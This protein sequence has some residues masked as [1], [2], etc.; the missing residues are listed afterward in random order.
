MTGKHR[1]AMDLALVALLACAATVE[2]QPLPTEHVT[3]NAAKLAPAE[4]LRDFVRT[5]TARSGA[6]GKMARWKSGIC[7]VVT[8]LPEAHSKFVTARVRQVARQVGAPVGAA[9]CKANIDI[10][11]TL[12]PQ[13]LM[14]DVRQKHHVYL[15]Y[16]EV[17][18]EARL[19][20][21]THPVQAWYTT[22]TVDL[23]GD[24]TVDDKLRNNGGYSIAGP[25]GTLNVTEPAPAV[26]VTG[27]R[28]MDGLSSELY[29][30]II[31]V[32]LARVHG[33]TVGALADYAAMLAL[34]QT[35]SFEACAPV[36]SITNLVSPD[37]EA[38]L[39]ADEITDNDLAYLS[40][41]YSIDPRG[42]FAHQQG[43][44]ATQMNKGR[45]KR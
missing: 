36:A 20:T 23:Q 19:A 12:H 29:H 22:Q 24:A 25:M 39:K 10:V 42:S 14:D 45:E 40:G 4:K 15:G 44:I 41:L 43:D 6:A 3:V 34:A 35:Q 37:C 30:V 31:I 17:A 9:T 16:H 5:Y 38:S 7:P 32:D 11:F 28:L 21:V 26:H 1:I 33:Q 2:A 18:E 8:G 27:S 13:V